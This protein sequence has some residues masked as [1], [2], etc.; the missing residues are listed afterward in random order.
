M[1]RK[2]GIF[3]WDDLEHVL[4]C[5]LALRL[6]LLLLGKHGTNKTD[7]VKN[8]SRSF[9]G[10][11]SKIQKYTVPLL[12]S[13]D[14]LGY[15]NPHSL[16]ENK[17]EYVQTNLSV[18]DKNVIILDELTADNLLVS[19]KILELIRSKEI[20][21]NV[22]DSL[23]WVTATCNPPGQEYNV[24]YLEPQLVS[25]FV[26]LEVP[27][28]LE[29]KDMINVALRGN[30]S[31]FEKRKAF[32]N[33]VK[34]MKK[35]IDVVEKPLRKRAAK[36]AA[37]IARTLSKSSKG[38]YLSGRDMSKM[39]QLIYAVLSTKDLYSVT[40]DTI[41]TIVEACVPDLSG[42]TRT[43]IDISEGTLRNELLV[44]ATALVKGAAD[45]S[46]FG[47]G[48]ALHK[49]AFDTDDFEPYD[50]YTNAM[51]A[52]K[53]TNDYEKAGKILRKLH[54]I[55]VNEDNDELDTLIKRVYSEAALRYIQ[56]T[57][58]YDDVKLHELITMITTGALPQFPK[59]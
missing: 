45:I 32:K 41:L 58:K 4:L 21:G 14:L 31:N 9:F 5:S 20:M 50:W 34:A 54:G 28:D 27:H 37:E 13:S 3:G 43:S 38:I 19:H 59:I 25:R 1:L 39:T 42:L 51:T 46:V 2:I 56:N 26:C 17:V 35:K 44:I 8:I 10:K 11:K 22:I 55:A 12:S 18:Q 57:D 7:G 53:R 6:P 23:K 16:K 15:P 48:S 29:E 52:L 36:A 49:E 47:E 40:T 24:A 33:Y 30:K